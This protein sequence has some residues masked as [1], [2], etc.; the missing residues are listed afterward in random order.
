MYVLEKTGNLQSWPDIL[1]SIEAIIAVAFGL[2]GIILSI[3][4]IYVTIKQRYIRVYG[5]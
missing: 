1:V 4:A 3:G 2:A 5:K